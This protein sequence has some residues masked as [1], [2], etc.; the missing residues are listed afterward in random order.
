[1]GVPLKNKPRN[2]YVG[3]KSSP[4]LAVSKV[5]IKVS[6]AEYTTFGVGGEADY[7]CL[8]QSKDD[9][10]ELVKWCAQENIPFLVIGNGSNLLVKDKGFRGLAIKLGKCF[11]KVSC[12]N[13]TI[14]AGAA[15]S[16]PALLRKAKDF[17]LGGLEPLAGIPGTAGGAI[18]TNAGANGCNMEDV[19]TG[20]KIMDSRGE[21]VLLKEKIG[22]S[23]R[24]SDIDPE[25]EVILEVGFSLFGKDRKEIEKDIR[26][27]L[28]ERKKRQPWGRKSAGCVFKNPQEGPA[29]KFIE[30][31]GLK[32]LSRGGA[33]VSRIH[34]NFI[35]NTGNAASSDILKLMEIVQ[36]RVRKKFGIILEPEIK[37]V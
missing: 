10:K 20:L 25:R 31:A 36:N 28:N 2:R 27:N 4:N 14:T 7:F 19:V 34:A 21:K 15:V 1:M 9:L 11:K 18:I 32:G 16:L 8:A 35:V 12:L 30:E 29:A 24:K 37:I 26:K 33:E 23:Y 6:L 17:S 13:E 22:F 5:K 3:V